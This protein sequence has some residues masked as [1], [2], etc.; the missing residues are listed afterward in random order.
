MNMFYQIIFN[1]AQ[2]SFNS[3]QLYTDR[4]QQ[5][6]THLYGWL[7]KTHR[8]F[9]TRV[10]PVIVFDGKPDPLNRLITKNYLVD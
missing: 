5:V 7:Q 6:I 9:K 3:Q 8:F 2:A 1:P 10:L 4:T